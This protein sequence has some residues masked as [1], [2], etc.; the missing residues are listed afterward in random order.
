MSVAEFTAALIGPYLIAVGLAI[1]INGKAFRAMLAEVSDDRGL[2]FFAGLIALAIGATL[3]KLHNVWVLD[4]PVL[5][6]IL[7]W[8]S[9]IGG[10]FRIIWPEAAAALARRFSTNEVAMNVLA[11]VSVLAGATLI[12]FGFFA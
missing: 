3:I 4:W 11:L 2:I 6:T 9:L 12:N 1:L 5:V 10:F 8:L 7:G